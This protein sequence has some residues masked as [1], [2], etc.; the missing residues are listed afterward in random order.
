MEQQVSSSG[1]GLL[2]VGS[3]PSQNTPWPGCDTWLC[4]LYLCL[5][6]LRDGQQSTC[7][8]S[9]F[10]FT[11]MKRAAGWLPWAQRSPVCISDLC[12]KRAHFPAHGVSLPPH[13]NEVWKVHSSFP[14][15]FALHTLLATKNNCHNVSCPRSNLL[16]VP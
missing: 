16:S 5:R 6:L 2:A 13:I 9:G 3:L 12:Y 4:F 8:V 11:A 14:G 7:L 1:Q 10:R 15:H